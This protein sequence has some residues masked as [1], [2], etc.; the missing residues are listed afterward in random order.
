LNVAMLTKSCVT[1]ESSP[2]EGSRLICK[3]RHQLPYQADVLLSDKSGYSDF[4]GVTEV[5][6]TTT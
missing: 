1:L 5:P 4:E 6:A 2:G 3:V